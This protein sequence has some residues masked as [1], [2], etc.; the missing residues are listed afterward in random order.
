MDSLASYPHGEEPLL[1]S[2][3]FLNQSG[4]SLHSR[5]PKFHYHIHKSPTHPA[6]DQSR[7]CL[8]SVS[9]RSFWILHVYPNYA[10]SFPSGLSPT[11]WSTHSLH[12]T[13]LSSIPTT[14]QH[15]SHS[16]LS[17]ISQYVILLYHPPF[18]PPTFTPHK[19]VFQLIVVAA[20]FDK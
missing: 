18:H 11:G 3:Q 16:T 13:L 15:P 5:N 1:R 4:N 2:Q 12:E 17:L 6:P 7:P 20:G 19:K 14:S 8:P 10:L 9:L